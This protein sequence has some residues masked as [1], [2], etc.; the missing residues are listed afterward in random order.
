MFLTFQRVCIGACLRSLQEVGQNPDHFL[1]SMGL[2]SSG[3]DG[4]RLI[5]AKGNQRRCKTLCGRCKHQTQTKRDAGRITKNCHSSHSNTRQKVSTSQ[6]CRVP[7]VPMN[8]FGVAAF[9]CPSQVNNAIC[10]CNTRSGG[11]RDLEVLPSF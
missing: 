3:K 2:I 4:L 5:Q 11:I 1:N 6:E 10:V 7:S 9:W 8:V